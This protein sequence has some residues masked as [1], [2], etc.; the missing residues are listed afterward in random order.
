MKNR[1]GL[2]KKGPFGRRSSGL[3]K[4]V[5]VIFRCT[6]KLA[7]QYYKI[8]IEKDHAKRVVK[9]KFLNPYNKGES[10]QLGYNEI[11]CKF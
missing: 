1:E 11:D 8:S 10:L 7:D 4:Q 5:E 6:A 9:M 3:V 2:F